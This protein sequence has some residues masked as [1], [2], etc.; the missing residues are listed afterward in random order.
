MLVGFYTMWIIFL[1]PQDSFRNTFIVYVDLFLSLFYL[2]LL[3]FIK[4]YYSR[5]G[6]LLSKLI[7]LLYGN[8]PILYHEFAIWIT[9]HQFILFV[10][11][12][13]L[14][15]CL[16]YQYHFFPIQQDCIICLEPLSTYT[17]HLTHCQCRIHYHIQCL[18]QWI[19]KNPQCPICQK[20]IHSN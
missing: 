19:D 3:F 11:D 18:Y 12:S 13:L 1:A 10:S 20:K 8:Y 9:L 15:F 17:I 4:F 14:F 5:I 7:L 6:I 16:N 2:Y